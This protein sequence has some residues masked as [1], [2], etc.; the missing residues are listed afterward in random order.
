MARIRGK[1]QE[2]SNISKAGGTLES[3]SIEF[4]EDPDSIL[5]EN[6]IASVA[7]HQRE[8]NGEQTRNRM[9]AGS[10]SG[11]WCFKAP[12]G[13]RYERR[14]GHGNILVRDEALETIIQEAFE[15]LASGRFAA[16]VEVKRFFEA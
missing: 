14:P 5:V 6:L 15:G 1:G 12:L 4:G 11:Y 8:K 3:P 9:W 10:L 16:Q 13:F 7:Q 2:R